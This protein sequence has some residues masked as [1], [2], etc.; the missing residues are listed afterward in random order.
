[1]TT[2]EGN[3][4][5]RR[6]GAHRTRGGA[7]SDEEGSKTLPLLHG[8][9]ICV[10]NGDGRRKSQYTTLKGHFLHIG[11][12]PAGRFWTCS[13]KVSFRG[14]KPDYCSNLASCWV[15]NV[16]MTYYNLNKDKSHME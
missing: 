3:L 2:P 8:A 5:G 10:Y 7:K 11:D 16:P 1:M 4:G 12:Y 6:H 9:L 13:A 14:N 15:V